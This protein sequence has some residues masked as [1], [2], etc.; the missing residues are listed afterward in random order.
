[1]ASALRC[2]AESGAWGF[3]PLSGGGEG[4]MMTMTSLPLPRHT[5]SLA[6]QLRCL[7]P[8]A[9][10]QA[11]QRRSVLLCRRRRW[12]QWWLVWRQLPP[13]LL[14]QLSLLLLSLLLLWLP[15]WL[16]LR[17]RLRH[18]HDLRRRT[19]RATCLPSRPG[20][21]PSR[22]RRRGRG[23]RRPPL[24]LPQLLRRHHSPAQRPP[25]HAAHRP[26]RPPADQPSPLPSPAAAVRQRQRRRRG[27][28]SLL[29][30]ACCVAPRLTPSPPLP[31]R[32][33][34]PPPCRGS[35]CRRFH[36]RQQVKTTVVAAPPS[37]PRDVY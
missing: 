9:L 20:G 17:L 35:S 31:W 28:P 1:M 10:S 5:S 22:G 11:L 37:Q 12:Q 4:V 21:R 32:G 24:P 7:P 26:P 36:L 34:M 33:G 8:Q 15:R 19:Q 13:L 18:H 25:R 2:W 6:H 3:V 29:A 23:R 27:L 14:Q 16:Q 30:L